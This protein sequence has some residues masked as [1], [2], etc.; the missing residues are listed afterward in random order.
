AQLIDGTSGLHLW[1]HAFAA[2]AAAG[3]AAVVHALARAVA[4][5]LA[6]DGGGASLDRARQRLPADGDARELYFR[7]RYL[8][9]RHTAASYRD[10]ARLFAQAAAADPGCALAWAGKAHAAIGLHGMAAAPD[11]AVVAE[12]R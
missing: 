5:S 6:R 1:S 8:M 10:A 12:A 4:R 9:G 7:A 3:L 2:E 11:G